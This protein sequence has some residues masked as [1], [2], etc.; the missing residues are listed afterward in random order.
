LVNALRTCGAVEDGP[1]P[2]GRG[3]V[4]SITDPAAFLRYVGSH[5]PQGLEVD[6]NSITDRANAVYQLADAKAIKQGSVQGIF[7]R[8]TKPGVVIQS[9]DGAA[10]VDVCQTTNRGGGAGIQLSSAITWKFDGDIVV[11]ENAET[12]WKHELVF[13]DVDIAIFASGGMSGRLITWLSAPEMAQCPITHWGD[14]DPYGVCEYL[15]LVRACGDRVSVFA[16]IEVDELLP[17]F[18]KRTLVTKQ[19]TYLD[20]L[21]SHGANSY[22]R[23][24]TDLFDKHR[25]GLEQEL[26]LLPSNQL[27]SPG[28]SE[29]NV[30]PTQ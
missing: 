9:T 12:F 10:S 27:R 28:V 20:R 26:L 29:S 19:S 18:G 17:R 2:C 30:Q 14:Y 16:P 7:V 5:C 11:I 4:L 23:R 25:R 8:S 22:V 15:R 6:I 24:M 3:V 1:A 21:R 13:P